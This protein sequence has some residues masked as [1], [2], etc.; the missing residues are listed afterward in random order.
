MQRIGPYQVEA[1]LGRGGMGVVY[2][3]RD[4]QDRVLALKL[5]LPGVAS[6]EAMTRFGREAEVMGRVNHPNVIR[7]HSLGRAPEGPYMVSELIEG[8]E[9]KDRLRKGPLG[10]RQVASLLRCLA[11]A[12]A[13]CHREGVLHRDLKPAN[14]M[15]RSEDGS[16]VLLD[17]GI[18]QDQ[19]AE[20]LTKTGTLMGTPNYMSP[21]QAAGE[22]VDGL[23]DVY[24]LG[25]ILYSCLAGR[26]PFAGKSSMA[27]IKAVLTD[28]LVPPSSHVSEVDRGLEA[29]CQKA[30]AKEKGERY[31]TAEQLR[32]DLDRYLG[33]DSV[34]ALGEVKTQNLKRRIGLGVGVLG[35]VLLGLVGAVVASWGEDPV[36]LDKTQQAEE[37]RA[38]RKARDEANRVKRLMTLRGADYL[39]AAEQWW[40]EHRH[41]PGMEAERLE[42]RERYLEYGLRHPEPIGPALPSGGFWVQLRRLPWQENGWATILGRNDRSQ[43]LGLRRLNCV[44]GVDARPSEH[45]TRRITHVARGSRSALLV[46]R[47]SRPRTLT[48][49]ERDRFHPDVPFSALNL[50]GQAAIYGMAVDEARGLVALACEEREQQKPR[51]SAA[52]LPL[53]SRNVVGGDRASGV[54]AARGRRR[55]RRGRV[56]RDDR[57]QWSIPPGE[58]ESRHL[59]PLL[60]DRRAEQRSTNQRVGLL[61]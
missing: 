60:Q 17:F 16:P 48:W 28:P 4:D 45:E 39:R 13:A 2:R 54:W 8:E 6:M 32:D 10:A 35:L 5:I 21:E 29:I 61:V 30:M 27:L 1:E 23:T 37:R 47:D 3:V 52:A 53:L 31:Q 20:Q 24:G 22:K 34:V 55:L 44:T 49:V 42:V 38:A 25:A 40:T 15:L 46:D 43:P 26:P 18:A 56:V 58:C 41:T 36:D 19:S 7:I 9:L 14:V 50:S 57:R 51:G 59:H 11:D 33:G 12:I